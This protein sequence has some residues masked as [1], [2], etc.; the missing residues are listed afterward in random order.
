[1]RELVENLD[2]VSKLT[3]A[4][5]RHSQAPA[6]QLSTQSSTN[7]AITPIIGNNSLNNQSIDNQQAI[8][9]TIW[10][11]F[12]YSMCHPETDTKTNTASSY[13]LCDRHVDQLLLCSVYLA[14]KLLSLG[15]SFTEI[16]RVYRSLPNAHPNHI[17]RKVLVSK[18]LTATNRNRFSDLVIFY[19]ETFIRVLKPFAVKINELE[20]AMKQQSKLSKVMKK[21][22]SMGDLVCLS[23]VPKL[24]TPTILQ[25]HFTPV[26]LNVN[27]ESNVFVSPGK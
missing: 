3:E 14:C 17:Y 26:K 18:L 20:R 16:I 24:Q 9:R 5:N 1:M 10:N 8:L 19:N 22:Q 7:P 12:E 15:V 11:I 2:L 6:Q 27:N 25:T 13:L 21:S 4:T 23:P